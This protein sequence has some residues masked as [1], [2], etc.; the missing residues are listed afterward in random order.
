M[1]VYVVW[2]R[3]GEGHSWTL[4][5]N[6]LLPINS[7]I[8]QDEKDAPMAGVEN[9]NPSTPAPPVDSKPADTGPSGMV[10]SSAAGNAPQ[11]SLDQ[12]APLRYGTQ[13]TQIQ[14]LWTYQN[15]GLQV[16]T[17]P[18]NIWD[19]WAGLHVISGVYNAFWGST[20]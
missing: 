5:R 13:K 4:Q 17:R 1:P 12:P 11:G 10:T 7:N 16:N 6:Y 8:G 20:V 3:N 15:F 14:L 19:A 9:T 2:P 18:P